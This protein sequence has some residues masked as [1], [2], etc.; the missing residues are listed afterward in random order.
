MPQDMRDANIVTL[1]K[2]KGERSDCNRYRGI[3]L[4]SIVGKA[5]ACVALKKLQSLAEQVYPESQCGFRAKRSTIDIIFSLRQLQEKCREQRLPLYITFIDLTKAFD[6]VSR[7]SLFRLFQRIGCP[8]KLL[9]IITS[10]DEEMQGTVQFDGSSSEPFPIKSGVK[11]GCVLA[12]TL[13]GI[14]FSLLLGYAFK[15][16]EEGAYIYT[17]SDG[18]L[19]NLSRL[20]AKTKVRKVLIRE[21]LFADDAALAA[22]TEAGLQDLINCFSDACNEF[23]LTI[24]I[25]KTNVLGQN[26]SPAPSISIGDSSLD[27]VEEFTYLGS[28]ISCSLNLDLELNGR[29]GKASSIMGRLS[30]R[31]WENTKLTT[32]TKIAVYQACVLSTLMYGSECWTLY[33]RQE[34]RLNTF[35]L[36]CI[37]RNLSISWQQH[38]TND[39]VLKRAGIPSMFSIL[40]KRRLRW[41]GHVARMEDGRIP[42]D[43]LYGELATGSRL[44]GRPT[45]R[46]KDVCKRDLRAGGIAPTDPEALA[47]DR[48]VWRL[49]TKFAAVKIQQKLKEQHEMKRQRRRVRAASDTLDDTA[50]VCPTCKKTCRSRIGLYSHSRRCSSTTE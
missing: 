49:T 6:L 3:S 27:V 37:R 9:K 22:H 28:V 31:V 47:A 29:I 24:S 21:M 13:F 1:Y 20:R 19:F 43:M 5:F 30:R 2:N 41:L 16:N 32:N 23:G 48:N 38:I 25:K 42:K 44:A 17:R 15:G 7:S 39:E 4:L 36:R 26:V 11:Q 35:H 40:A 10:F 34:Q 50:F 45:L 33:S 18:S 14:L 12:P 46:Y 8:P